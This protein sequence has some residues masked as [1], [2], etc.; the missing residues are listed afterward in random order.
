MIHHFISLLC[1]DISEGIIRK[2]KYF[3]VAAALFSFTAFVFS[4]N[5]NSFFAYNHINSKAGVLDFLINVFAGNEPY[6]PE[7][8]KGIS[9]PMI[10]IVFHALLFSLVGFYI[11]DDLKKNAAPFILRVKSRWQWWTS[12]FVWCVL[13]VL[14]YYLL[15]FAVLC[16]FGSFSFTA[17]EKVALDFFDL[18]ISGVKNSDIFLASFILPMIISVSIAVLEAAVSLIIKPFYCFVFV[19]C[20]LA[21]S[22]FHCNLF[23]LF[24]F[25]M[26]NRNNLFSS[27]DKIT[28]YNGVLISAILI[29]LSYALGIFVI[30]K[31]D[32][33]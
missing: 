17:H 31:K 5:V 2:W 28:F 7:A 22:A 27:Y 21:A 4:K 19:V 1:H 30:K 10:W 29:V 24:N 9:L 15:F 33:L 25:A 8:H 26:L 20:Y 32:I 11:K 13:T 6:D 12:K 3:V 18:G 14:I 16:I 23:L